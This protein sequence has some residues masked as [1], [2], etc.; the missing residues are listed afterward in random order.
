MHEYIISGKIE[1]GEVCMWLI[2]RY[3]DQKQP[4]WNSGS[5]P[6]YTVLGRIVLQHAAGACGRATSAACSLLHALS[7]VACSGPSHACMIY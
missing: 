3:R 4:D 5:P 6:A 1:K 2:Y 7:N